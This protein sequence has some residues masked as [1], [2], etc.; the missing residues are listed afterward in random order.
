MQA[1]AN[2]CP[3][4]TSVSLSHC[5]N[6]TDAAVQALANSRSP[7]LTTVAL[8]GCANM[9]GAKNALRESINV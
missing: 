5:R 6:V 7:N 2:S 9:T 3:N 4:L 1:L 8:S